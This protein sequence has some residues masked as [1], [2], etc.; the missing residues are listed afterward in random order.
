[1]IRR[2][3][4]RGCRVLPR[5]PLQLDPSPRRL[6]RLVDLPHQPR[7]A[8]AQRDELNPQPVELVELGVGRQLGIEDQFFRISPRPFLPEPDE[9][10]DLIVLLILAQFTIGVAEDAGLGVLRQEGQDALLSP[11]PLGD[12]VLLDQGILAMEGDRVKIQ[13][14]GMTARQTEPAHGVEPAAHQLRVAARVDPATVLGQ[15]RSLG[16]D[17]Q[18]GEEGQP[19]VQHHAHDMAV[20]CRPEQLQGQERSQG[21]A[22]WDHLRSGEPRRSEDAIEGNRGQHR[23][24]EEQTAEFGPERP[25]AQVELPDV[26][27]IGRGRPRARWAFVVG[28]ARQPSESFVLE[29]LCDGDRAERMSLVGQIAADVI[30]GEVL[31]AQGDDAVA[32]GVGLGCGL[33][34]LSR[35]EEEVASGILAELVDEDS[36][37]PWGVTEAMRATSA[38]GRPSTKKAR[39]A[40]YWRW[41]ALVGSRKRRE[42]SVSSLGSLVNIVPKCQIGEKASRPTSRRAKTGGKWGL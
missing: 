26:G 22:G 1:M 2:S 17:V 40:S 10:E 5:D 37:A 20:A 25:R 35:R 6:R 15:E 11:T 28:P 16:D 14:E 33:G 13:V 29:D 7:G 39:R 12:V 27:D 32:E 18:A 36:E 42:R 19:L 41:V 24:E 38:L 21:G 9:A 31:F 3:R 30:D 23:Q 8:P 34:S 4:I